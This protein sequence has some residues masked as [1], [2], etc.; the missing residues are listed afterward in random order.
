VRADRKHARTDGF[1]KVRAQS[2]LSKAER[3]RFR[4][5]ARSFAAGARAAA[6]ARIL[7]RFS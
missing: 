1:D 7:R 4:G 6:T 3:A 2:Y 5:A